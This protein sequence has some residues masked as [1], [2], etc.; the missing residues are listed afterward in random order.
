MIIGRIKEIELLNKNY[1]S[2][3]SE[4]IAL[5]GRRRVGKTY[6]VRT[7]FK[8][9]FTFQLTGLA[10]AGL[11]D[12]LINFNMAAQEQGLLKKK[13]NATNWME[14]F[15]QIREG[16]QRSNQKKKIIFIDEL[17]WFD[18][19]QASFIPALEHFWN[20]WVSARKDV[21][22]IVCGS[23]ASWM[24]HKLINNKGGLHNRV[25]QKIKI[26]PFTLSECEQLLRYK[27]INIDK[28][29]TIQ[30]YMVLGGI[31]F[32]WDAVQKGQSAAQTI[33]KLC[34][35]ANGLLT[36]EFQNLYA[37]L[38]SK[39]ER[40]KAIVLA[41]SKKNKGLT[42][43]EVSQSSKLANGGGLTR[44]LDELEES[45]FIRKYTP[46]GKKSR[47]SLYQLSDFFTLFHLKF[48]EG[49]KSFAKNYWVKMIDHPTQRA[50]SGYAFEQVCLAHILQIKQALGISGV[51]TQVSSWKTLLEKDG[52]Q[53]DLVI[54]RRDGVINLCEMK[55]S[56]NQFSIDK[57]YDSVLRNKTG[58]FKRETKTRK[59]LFITLITTFGLQNNAYSGNIQNDL[60][61]D[62]LFHP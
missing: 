24:I 23:A 49:Q 31:P 59:A 28:Y 36:S 8:K 56:I 32:Y 47:N 45:G 37:S 30:L 50:W 11:Q 4:F 14:A 9:E 26:E 15:Q 54:D 6:L 34:F 18:T 48:M 57:K 35:D 27:K 13:K 1:K 2:S 55:F 51:E 62:V 29:Q 25:T 39:A 53:I 10:Q 16:I 46:F 3:K 17:P 58:A 40:H 20:S 21:L 52:A 33:D 5:Y 22:L 44:L 42:R 61:M 41:L 38:F 60:K 43:S 12:Q 7:L 19:P